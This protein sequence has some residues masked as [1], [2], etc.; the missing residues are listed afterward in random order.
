MQLFGQFIKQ[1][2]LKALLTQDQVADYL[3]YDNAEIMILLENRDRFW[4]VQHVEK[5]ADLF[6]MQPGE[7]MM[8]WIEN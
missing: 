7:L 5:L 6:D 2:Y 8:E 3:G 4:T 1:K